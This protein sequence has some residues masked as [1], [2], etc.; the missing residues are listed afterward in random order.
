MGVHHTPETWCI[1]NNVLNK[2]ISII[3]PL[4]KGPEVLYFASDKATLIPGICSENC[5]LDDSII[6]LPAFRSNTSEM[7]DIHVTLKAR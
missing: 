5:N 7:H 4:F 2:G 6:S 3:P 1:A